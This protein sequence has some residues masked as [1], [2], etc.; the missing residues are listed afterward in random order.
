MG[1]GPQH[2]EAV[3]VWRG[4]K[5]YYLLLC[6]SFPRPCPLNAN[7]S[8]HFLWKFKHSYTFPYTPSG[9]GTTPQLG[10][11]ESLK[12]EM[13]YIQKWL[14]T[15]IKN[16]PPLTFTDLGSLCFTLLKW[17]QRSWVICHFAEEC[18]WIMF[19]VRL[20]CPDPSFSYWVRSVYPILSYTFHIKIYMD[21]SFH[22][23]SL[24]T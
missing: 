17:M 11:T 1:G 6:F 3:G 20:I 10:T 15:K 5:I 9:S 13:N 4:A 21:C 18:I 19:G 16:S 22:V 23:Y 12:N 24:Q 8:L 14:S 2:R 7:N